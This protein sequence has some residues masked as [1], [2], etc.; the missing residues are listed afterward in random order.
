MK[1]N[2]IYPWA[3]I[4]LAHSSRDLGKSGS[5]LQSAGIYVHHKIAPC[6]A[7]QLCRLT[8]QS[9]SSFANWEKIEACMRYGQLQIC[10]LPQLRQCIVMFNRR[11]L[12]QSFLQLHSTLLYVSNMLCKCPTGLP[13]SR[14]RRL[15]V[16]NVHNTEVPQTDLLMKPVLE[17]PSLQG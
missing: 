14:K 8:R 13:L 4:L 7:L 2:L 15:S 3:R 5:I 10:K 9:F 1:C 17:H 16:L 11:S 12:T 6:T